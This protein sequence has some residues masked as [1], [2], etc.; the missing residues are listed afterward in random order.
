MAAGTL[1][2]YEIRN[3]ASGA[4]QVK[5]D[6]YGQRFELRPATAACVPAQP[7]HA[8]RDGDWLARRA[9]WD[10]LHAPVSIYEL[11][12]GSW[13]RHPDGRFYSY[14]ELAEHLLPYVLD[15]GFTH[16]ELLPVSEHPLDESWGY[17]TTGYFAPTRRFGS[18][19]DLRGFIDA[20]HGAGIGVLLDWAPGHF[21]E[22][23]F[24]LAHFDGSS[25]Y[26]H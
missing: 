22:D 15:M 23:Q 11:H 18:A 12:A 9:Q 3:R 8:W 24:A 19:D 14:R 21:P 26:E 13:R 2:K 4:V 25:L 10:W 17:Q 5:S 6:P 20:C 16:I 7:A 1:Y